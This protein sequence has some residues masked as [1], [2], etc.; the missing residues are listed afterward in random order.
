M[1]VVVA[2][3]ADDGGRAGNV[4]RI[5]FWFGVVGSA[6]N[7]YWLASALALYTKLAFLGY[8]ATTARRR[9]KGWRWRERDLQCRHVR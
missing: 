9:P 3:Q 1:A 2:R 5:A 4:M 8:A 6:I 7:L